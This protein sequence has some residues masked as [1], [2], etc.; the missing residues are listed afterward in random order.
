MPK[1]KII[2]SDQPELRIGNMKLRCKESEVVGDKPIQVRPKIGMAKLTRPEL[3]SDI[4]R[5]ECKRSEANSMGLVQVTP[6]GKNTD[7]RRARLC[8]RSIDPIWM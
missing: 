7:S 6:N 3:R 4:V 2:S 5:P 8:E 1:I